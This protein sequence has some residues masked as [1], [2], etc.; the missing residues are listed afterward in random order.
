[1]SMNVSAPWKRSRE[2]GHSAT[3]S[4]ARRAR[5]PLQSR[6]WTRSQN[7]RTTAAFDSDGVVTV[8]RGRSNLG[9]FAV[10]DDRV[11]LLDA[12]RV[13]HAAGRQTGGLGAGDGQPVEALLA[14]DQPAVLPVIGGRAGDNEVLRLAVAGGDLP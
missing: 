11:L 13:A 6:A 9:R 5:A 3:K 14:L 4:S 7:R 8:R 12:V 10:L 1:M 2:W